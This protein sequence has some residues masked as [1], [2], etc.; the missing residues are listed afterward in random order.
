MR[1]GA[2]DITAWQAHKVGLQTDD[3]ATDWLIARLVRGPDC[4]VL[5]SPCGMDRVALVAGIREL[6]RSVYGVP[7]S[8]EET[9]TGSRRENSIAECIDRYAIASECFADAIVL[10]ERMSFQ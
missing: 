9:Q 2:A 4:A 8:A 7:L 1:M 6:H 3:D 10:S 5:A